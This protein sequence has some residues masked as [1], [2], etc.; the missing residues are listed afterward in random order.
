VPATWDLGFYAGLTG[1]GATLALQALRSLDMIDEHGHPRREVLF[2]ELAARWHTR[3]YHLTH[4]PVV[5]ELDEEAR[6]L[7]AGQADLR[8]PGWAVI[9]STPRGENDGDEDP[10]PHLLLADQRALAWLLRVCGPAVG[11]DAASLVAAAPSPVAVAQ[12]QRPDG[13]AAW[14]AVHPVVAA[15][16]RSAPGVHRRLPR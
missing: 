1:S 6:L 4:L 14:P 5:A 2:T 11:P 7:I 12:R 8:Q 9:P 16:E 13:N 15:L 3:W 10:P